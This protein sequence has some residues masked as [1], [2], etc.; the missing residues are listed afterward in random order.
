MI[1]QWM[2]QEES[3]H[4]S[5]DLILEGELSDDLILEGEL[6]DDLILLD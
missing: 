5:D 3:R 4:L 1:S 2:M 6:S